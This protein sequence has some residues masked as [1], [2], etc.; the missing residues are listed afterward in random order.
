MKPHPSRLLLA[1]AL[2]LPA[3]LLFACGGEEAAA[4]RYHCPMHPTFVADQPGDCPICGMRLV[5]M[6]ERTAAAAPAPRPPD[7]RRVLFYRSPMD[8][9]VTS[10][11]PAKDEMGME[12]VPVYEDELRATGSAVEG[13]G[14]VTVGEQGLRLAGVQSVA[15]RRETLGRSVRTVGLVVPD[16]RRVRHVHT[17]IS[18]WIEKLYANFT[19]QEVRRGQP[20]LTLYSP[21]LLATQEEF[22]RARDAA[23]RFAGSELPEVRKGG[24]DL[25]A[26]ARRRLELFDVPASLVAEIEESGRPQR[27]VTLLAPVSGFVTSKDVFEGQQ[28]EPGMELYTITDLSRVWVEAEFYEYEAR[29]LRVGQQANLFLPYDPDVRLTGE[30]TYVAPTLD[31]ESRTLEVRLEFS[32]QDGHLRPGMFA[33]VVAQLGMREGIVVPDSAIL[34]SGLRQIVF[35]ERQTGIYEPREVQVVTRSEGKALLAGGISEGERVA[36]RANFL[37]DSESRLR[38][39]IAAMAGGER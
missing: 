13:R 33:D 15:A 12:Y 22:L 10:P 36:V 3:I 17:K 2:L 20:M 5:P 38:A 8:P 35:V 30:V 11:V 14:T 25:L 28:I 37:L 7:E 32:N 24:E 34:D 18:G 4:T 16:E 39:A 19:G 27:T 6:E 1:A 31:A 26:A 21:E 9:T 23:T 29:A